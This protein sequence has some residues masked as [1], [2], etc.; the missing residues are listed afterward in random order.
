MLIICYII[1]ILEKKKKKIDFVPI[2]SLSYQIQQTHTHQRIYYQDT[3]LSK[4]LIIT[5]EIV[6]SKR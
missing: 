5:D 1:Y 3:Q 2:L 6:L 4:L